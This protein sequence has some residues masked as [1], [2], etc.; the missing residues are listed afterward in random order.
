MQIQ[1]SLEWKILDKA[2][3]YG[4]GSGKCMLCL[5][6]KYHILFSKNSLLNSHSELKT[7][8]WHEN[9]FYLSNYKDTLP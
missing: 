4:P 7:K 6:E 8:C 5:T 1:T 9:K 2:K 3:S